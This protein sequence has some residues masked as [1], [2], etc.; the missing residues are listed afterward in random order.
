MMK[1]QQSIMEEN[2]RRVQF[3]NNIEHIEFLEKLNDAVSGLNERLKNSENMESSKHVCL[4]VF[5]LYRS[6][7]SLTY[8]LLAN[9]LNVIFPNNISARFWKNPN[10]GFKLASIITSEKYVTEYTPCFGK[11]PNAEGVHEYSYF[12]SDILHMGDHENQF[13]ERPFSPDQSKKLRE[14]LFSLMNAHDKP[15]LFK[16]ILGVPHM[17]QIDATLDKTLWIYVQRDFTDTAISQY[18]SRIE[19]YGTPDSWWGLYPPNFEEI[20]HLSPEEQIAHSMKRISEI[21]GKK[22]EG[23]DN[24]IVL[25]YKDVCNNPTMTIEQVRMALKRLYDYS[26]DVRNGIPERFTAKEYALD[27][28]INQRIAK[29]VKAICHK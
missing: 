10:V 15:L 3:K 26:I 19:Y 11:F 12:W 16:N 23:K 27:T 5:G 17:D 13:T 21:Y 24:V 7:T 1:I 28:D 20:R 9:C 6:G 29:A 22:I 2:E 18:N 25:R 8:Q 4:M 14:T